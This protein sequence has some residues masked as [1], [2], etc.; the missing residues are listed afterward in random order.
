MNE[1][2]SKYISKAREERLYAEEKEDENLESAE[3]SE[4]D[5]VNLDDDDNKDDEVVDTVKGTIKR[6]FPFTANAES[7]ASSVAVVYISSSHALKVRGRTIIVPSKSFVPVMLEGKA[8]GSVELKYNEDKLQFE[9]VNK[10]SEPKE[11]EEE[12]KE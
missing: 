5:E 3:S 11:D 12:T 7:A 1:K 2:L 10:T 4:V 9:I 6:V 8:S